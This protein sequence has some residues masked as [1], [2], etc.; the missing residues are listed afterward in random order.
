[1][2]V[3]KTVCT[4][5]DGQIKLCPRGW[6]LHLEGQDNS[7]LSYNIRSHLYDTHNSH[8]LPDFIGARRHVGNRLCDHP[9]YCICITILSASSLPLS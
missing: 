7:R 4:Q 1:M 6:Y 3:F 2:Y 5:E 8:L 9:E